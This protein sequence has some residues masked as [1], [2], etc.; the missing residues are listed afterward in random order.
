MSR[1]CESLLIV[2]VGK[3]TAPSLTHA[4]T[5][6]VRLWPVASFDV[7]PTLST[8]GR[9]KRLQAPKQLEGGT[10]RCSDH[11]RSSGR[12]QHR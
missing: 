10:I 1:S 3:M 9:M 12:R 2:Q 11:G 5:Q 7:G 8:V 4:S 6:S